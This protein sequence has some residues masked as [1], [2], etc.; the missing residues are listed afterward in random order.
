MLWFEFV[1]VWNKYSL[2]VISEVSENSYLSR[3]VSYRQ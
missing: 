3:I 1:F 2:M